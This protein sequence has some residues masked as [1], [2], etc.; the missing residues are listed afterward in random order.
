MFDEQTDAFERLIIL[1]VL[2]RDNK[3]VPDYDYVTDL[4]NY[5]KK[6]ETDQD[7]YTQQVKHLQNKVAALEGKKVDAPRKR[8]QLLDDLL[9]AA[10]I[11]NEDLFYEIMAEM[12]NR[13]C[14]N[15]DAI[16]IDLLKTL[17]D[18]HYALQGRA[19]P[20]VGAI[21][22]DK[23]TD[24]DYIVEGY[25]IRGEIHI[26]YG[27]KGT[28]KTTFCGGMIRAGAA[29]IG[30]LEQVT[31]KK[32]CKF[33]FIQADGG[34]SRFKEVYRKLNL[35]KDQ[36]EVWGADADQ[37]T[38]NWTCDLRGMI[39]I[40]NRLDKGDIDGV[41]IDSVKGMLSS[42]PFKYTDNVVVD[43]IC[44][45]LREI[46]L[47]PYGVGMMLISHLDATGRDASGA[48]RWTEVAGWVGEIRNCVEDGQEDQ[49]KRKLLVLKDP[50][51][52]RKFLDYTFKDGVFTPTFTQQLVQTC[53]PAIKTFVQEQNMKTGQTRFTRK[54]FQAMRSK[55][56]DSQLTKNL[57]NHLQHGGIFKR[58]KDKN[59]REVPGVYLLK[60]QFQINKSQA[61]QLDI[62]VL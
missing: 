41:F 56:S 22:M 58:L 36:V 46:I 45:F 18:R 11:G 43:L 51:N 12:K 8:S 42:S 16:N 9:D 61:N 21:D 54:D 2:T 49:K 44:K 53:Y 34:A 47:E 27:G 52:D 60:P 23:V 39:M 20:V 30:F 28:G 24:L 3:Q 57:R 32:K 14:R 1:G 37:G 59:G 29:G 7:A 19:K 15:E 25:L 50:I 10:L 55:P 13:F 38:T 62:T 4:K 26:L 5:L 17:R 35:N 33:L 31:P 48:K 6:L 40:K